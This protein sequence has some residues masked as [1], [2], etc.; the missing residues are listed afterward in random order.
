MMANMVNV[1]GPRHTGEI[2]GRRSLLM[3]EVLVVAVC[4][5]LFALVGTCKWPPEHAESAV[6]ESTLISCSAK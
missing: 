5:G 3:T 1:Y 4:P 2:V 6:R